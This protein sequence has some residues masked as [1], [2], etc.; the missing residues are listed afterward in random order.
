MRQIESDFEFSRFDPDLNQWNLDPERTDIFYYDQN[1]YGGYASGTFLIGEKV[2]LITGLRVELTELAGDFETFEN[3]FDNQYL[4]FLP[5]VTLAKKTGEYNQIRISYNQRIQRPNQRHINPF[6]EYNDNRDISFGNPLLFPELVHQV[7]IGTTYFIEGNMISTSVFGR[8]TEDIIEN[9]ISI[10]DLGISE[11]TYYNFGSRNAVGLNVFGSLIIGDLAFRGGFD[12][13]AW[14]VNGNFEEQAL[15][16]EGIEFNGRMNITWTLNE[17]TRIEG[18][19]FTKALL[20]QSREVH[21]TG[22]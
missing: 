21:P 7:E 19:S 22:P 1:V 18:F 3:P 20:I 14:R 16:N 13:N 9:L 17:T 5:N 8:R 15:S 11:S 12:V 10:N 2:S 4:N 6:V